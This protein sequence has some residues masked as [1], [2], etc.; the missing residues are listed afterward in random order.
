MTITANVLSKLHTK[1]LLNALQSARRT[2]SHLATIIDRIVEERGLA[3]VE[4]PTEGLAPV[5][6]IDL[7]DCW[8]EPC[9]VTI[10]ELKAEL[11]KRP[12]VPN[13][14]EAKAIRQAKAQ[15]N[16]NKGRRAK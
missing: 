2:Q 13:K 4:Q 11:A 1:V 15:A 8:G 3:H 14:Q 5:E 6:A 16:K 12:H 10:A 9:T 7:G